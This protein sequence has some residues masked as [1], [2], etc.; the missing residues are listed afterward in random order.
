[1]AQK[2]YIGLDIGGTKILGGLFDENC[3]MVKRSKKSTKSSQGADVIVGQICKVIDDLLEDS[4]DGKLVAIGAGCP[5]IINS[6]EGIVVFS[7]NMNWGENFPLKEKMEKKYKVPFF[8]GNDANILAMGEYKFGAGAGCKNIIGIFIGTGIG[9]GIIINGKLYEGAVGAAGEI[10]HTIVL[11]DGPLCGCG[12]RGCLES[13]A[14]RTAMQR[15]IL[16][17]LKKGRTSVITEY[18]DKEDKMI[19]SSHLKNT[20]DKGDELVIEVVDKACYYLGISVGSLMNVFNPDL[21]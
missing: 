10:G 12:S 19:K 15:D 16:S 7:P 1:M 13:L 14:S 6:K 18:M 4:S 11:P 2:Y 17:Q 8:L 20:Y 3:K 9:G 21:V 5:G